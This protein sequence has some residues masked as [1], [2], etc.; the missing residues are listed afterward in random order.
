M[1]TI[2]SE[3]PVRIDLHTSESQ[4]H[5]DD[6]HHLSP[7]IDECES[8]NHQDIPHEHEHHTSPEIDESET[9]DHQAIPHEHELHTSPEIDE[10]ESQEDQD[11]QLE[12]EARYTHAKSPS[13]HINYEPAKTDSFYSVRLSEPGLAPPTLD[14]E[15]EIASSESDRTVEPSPAMRPLETLDFSNPF[16][17]DEQ[18]PE[19]EVYD[20]NDEYR[21]IRSST[22]TKR[23]ASFPTFQE[24]DVFEDASIHEPR[25]RSN[26]GSSRH[27]EGSGEVDWAGLE[28]TEMEEVRDEVSDEVSK[29][30][31]GMG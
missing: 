22:G 13:I 30:A 24:E 10:S 21:S 28:K 3:L 8:Q 26:S 31:V 19:A 29:L 9:Q 4:D 25:S 14:E 1:A 11:I 7:E 23:T 20:E 27:S 6:E 12:H 2:D 5:Q 16:V 18:E 15:L 17:D